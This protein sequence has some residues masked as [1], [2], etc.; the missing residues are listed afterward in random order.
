M[1]RGKIS[2]SKVIG[3]IKYKPMVFSAKKSAVMKTAVKNFKS[4]K[5]KPVKSIKY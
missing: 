4:K 2:A 3:K 1:A 5:I